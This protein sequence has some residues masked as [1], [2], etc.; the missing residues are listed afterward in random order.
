MIRARDLVAALLG[1]ALLAPL[2]ES[3]PLPAQNALPRVRSGGGSGRAT[4][5]RRRRSKEGEGLSE[6]IARALAEIAE[7]ARNG[8]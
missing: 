2:N 7:T 6:R 5:S 8:R 3:Q 4:V 1:N